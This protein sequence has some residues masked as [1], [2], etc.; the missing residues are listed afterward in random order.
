MNRKI[1]A[2]AMA[3]GIVLGGTVAFASPV[4]DFNKGALEIEFG[5]TLNSSVSGKGQLS[6]SADGKEGFKYGLAYGLGKD[7]A[8]QFKG[9]KF[10]SEDA[11]VDLPVDGFGIISRT[12]YAKSDIRELNLVYKINDNISAAVGYVENIISYG[13]S[14][15][16]KEKPSALH[17]GLIAHQKLDR[18]LTGFTGVMAG[19][20][21]LFW[22]AG[23]G[24]KVAKDTNLNIAYGERKFKDVPIVVDLTPLPPFN[25][26]LDYKMKGITFMFS[27]KLK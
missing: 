16:R 8:L 13:L 26:T 25:D 18:K 5:S 23:L 24:Y 3:L 11:T 9:G 7:L 21:V 6:P 14:T 15:V 20:D 10:W 17:A 4:N 22:E 2:L 12:T 27:H 1:V 19:K